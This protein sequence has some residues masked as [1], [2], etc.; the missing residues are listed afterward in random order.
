[1]NP[2]HTAQNPIQENGE[3]LIGLA[4]LMRMHFSGMDL[5]ALGQQLLDRA[6]RNGHDANALMDLSTILQLKGNRDVA[7]S[8]QGQAL[9]TRQLY[10]LR[11]A[12]GVAGI[13]LL[14]IMGAGDLM[15]NAPLEFLLEESDVALE[16][17]YVMPDQPFPQAVPDHDLAIVAV[18]ESDENRLLLEALAAAVELWPRPVLNRPERVL[19][20][21]RDRVWAALRSVPGIALPRAVRVGREVLEMLAAEK[22]EMSSVLEGGGFPVIIRPVGSHAGHGLEKV[23][24]PPG[25][26]DYLNANPESVFYIS[27]FV[28]YRSRDGQF[29]KYRIVLIEGQPYAA[30]MAISDHWM[31]HYLN[32]GMTESAEKRQEEAQFMAGFDG[33]FAVRHG[34]AFSAIHR[35]MGLEYLGIDCGETLD[36]RLLIFEVDSSMVVHNLDPV[37]LFP[38]KQAQMRKVFAAFRQMLARHVSSPAPEAS[39]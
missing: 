10:H 20:L 16:M 12:A 28:D 38:Y 35:E 11:P 13:H 3:P 8:V 39:A 26:A 1:M 23:D 19:G 33:D 14:A 15:S 27:P 30:H 18:G 2:E 21:S 32:A 37:D 17:L 25:V 7:M 29:R 31:I 36:G 24:G 22:A 4:T 5:T 9:Q 34:A 6:A